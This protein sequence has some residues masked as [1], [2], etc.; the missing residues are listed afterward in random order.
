MLH[1]GMIC[2][3]SKRGNSKADVSI[4]NKYEKYEKQGRKSRKTIIRKK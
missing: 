1:I 4:R 3:G 2:K